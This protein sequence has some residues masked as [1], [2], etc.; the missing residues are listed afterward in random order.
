MTDFAH[1]D[2]QAVNAELKAHSPAGI[3]SW[4][5]QHASAPLLTTNFRPYEA[6]ILHALTRAKSDIRVI[7]CDTGY[8]TSATYRHAQQLIALLNLNIRTYVPLQTSAYRNVLMG[9][10]PDIDDPQHA[11]FTEQVKLEP[12][13]RAM[14]DNPADVWFTNLRY[15][16][17]EHRNTLDVVSLDQKRNLLKVCPFFYCDDAKMDA[18]LQ[19]YNLP[20]EHDYYDPSKAEAKRECGLHL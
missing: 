8:N 5:L 4:A 14:D 17:T 3:I 11:L 16:Q 18:Y 12:F 1:L 6:A 15:G 13:A 7:W 19:Q 9:G 20:N 10:I 2:L